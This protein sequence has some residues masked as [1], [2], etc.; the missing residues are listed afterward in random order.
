MRDF[1]VDD[2]AVARAMSA[3]A[4][5]TV[6]LASPVK[7]GVEARARVIGWAEV[8]ELATTSLPAE[9]AEGLEQLRVRVLTAA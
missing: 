9:F 3:H 7:I 6:V 2:A 5:R 8:D 4:S 1:S